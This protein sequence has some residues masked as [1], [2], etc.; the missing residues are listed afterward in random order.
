LEN[1][2]ENWTWNDLQDTFLR[3]FQPIGHDTV[4]KI[5]LEKRKQGDSESITSFITEIENLCR[6]VDRQI[7]EEDI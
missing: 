4:L 3:E 5:K 6:Q 2:K 1:K 7:K